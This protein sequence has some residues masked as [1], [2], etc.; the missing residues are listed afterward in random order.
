MAA[1]ERGNVFKGA[2]VLQFDLIL[3]SHAVDRFPT[4]PLTI[5]VESRPPDYL[6]DQDFVP[7]EPDPTYLSS[8]QRSD[9]DV[10]QVVGLQGSGPENGSVA[11]LEYG[12]TA[13]W[14]CGSQLR[15]SASCT[16]A[17]SFD[18]TRWFTRARSRAGAADGASV[19]EPLQ[20]PSR[21]ART[22]RHP[23]VSPASPRSP[24]CLQPT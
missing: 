10:I 5:Q 3:A 17:V 11:H 21:H 2:R 14:L 13:T 12:V 8:D 1:S 23:G 22:V 19:P 24:E 18:H 20:K 6:P 7:T 15:Q 16:S 9:S 4:Y